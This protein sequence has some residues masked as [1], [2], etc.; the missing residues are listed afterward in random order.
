MCSGRAESLLQKQKVH[1]AMYR[2]SVKRW[3]CHD[4]SHTVQCDPAQMDLTRPRYTC[5]VLAPGRA[6]QEC[7]YK[8]SVT[9]SCFFLH[10]STASILPKLVAARAMFAPPSKRHV[11]PIHG[12]FCLRFLP[13]HSVSPPSLFHSLTRSKRP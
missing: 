3:I 12:E 7:L 8:S 9:T 1:C 5:T 2:K 6:G 10:H 13:R 11:L 4:F